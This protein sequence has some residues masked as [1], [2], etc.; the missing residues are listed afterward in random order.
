MRLLVKAWRTQLLENRLEDL[1][2]ALP[3]R[4]AWASALLYILNIYSHLNICALGRVSF[5]LKGLERSGAWSGIGWHGALLRRFHPAG[6]LAESQLNVLRLWSIEARWL[7]LRYVAVANLSWAFCHAEIMG[8]CII[9]TAC[10]PANCVR[11]IQWANFI[12]F[13]SSQLKCCLV[14]SNTFDWHFNCP[15]NPY[16]FGQP[17]SAV[18]FLSKY[19]KSNLFRRTLRS[20]ELLTRLRRSKRHLLS[21]HLTAHQCQCQ[22]LTR[23][24]PSRITACWDCNQPPKMSQ[25]NHLPCTRLSF[26]PILLRSTK[27]QVQDSL[28]PVSPWCQGV[29]NIVYIR[30]TMYQCKRPAHMDRHINTTFLLRNCRMYPDVSDIAAWH[31]I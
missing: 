19:R 3:V 7:L 21:H 11:T 31:A 17:S 20:I 30:N 25:I 23:G 26:P 12:V 14:L 9:T 22:A 8:T 16:T 5:G 6:L 24:A 15:Q 2:A 18:C 4:R 10:V 13:Y 29:S 28:A 1:T 27:V